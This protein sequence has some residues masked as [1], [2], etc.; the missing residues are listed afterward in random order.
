MNLSQTLRAR[1]AH[2][3]ADEKTG[4]RSA[5]TR[6]ERGCRLT[7]GLT[8]IELVIGG[9]DAEGGPGGHAVPAQHLEGGW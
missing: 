5:W 1:E 8:G 6:E 7:A 3:A 4:K 2:V 9:P